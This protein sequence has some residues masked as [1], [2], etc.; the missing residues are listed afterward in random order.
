[1]SFITSILNGFM[2]RSLSFGKDGTRPGRLELILRV[3]WITAEPGWEIVCG[4]EWE[5][6]AK[7][8]SFFG[9]N[10][11]AKI[12]SFSLVVFFVKS[13]LRE[14]E[15]DWQNISNRYKRGWYYLER[16][17]F[18]RARAS[19]SLPDLIDVIDSGRCQICRIFLFFGRR[20]S[21]VPT[22]DEAV[23]YICYGER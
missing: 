20:R 23:S 18:L 22:Y 2:N 16:F 17:S 3:E 1:M 21:P 7:K 9:G 6:K 19:L 8:L 12:S 11:R 13:T 14:Q 5:R 10:P 4:N 15:Q